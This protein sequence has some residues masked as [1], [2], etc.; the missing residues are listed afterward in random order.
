M[1]KGYKSVAIEIH[2]LYLLHANRDVFMHIGIEKSQ[3]NIIMLRV[4]IWFLAK[5]I[6]LFQSYWLKKRSEKLWYQIK[7]PSWFN[8]NKKK[9]PTKIIARFPNGHKWN[10]CYFPSLFFFLSKYYTCRRASFWA[11]MTWKTGVLLNS[12]RCNYT[13]FTYIWFHF[14]CIKTELHNCSIRYNF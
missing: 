12:L 13:F 11:W 8:N 7:T 4:D 14:T 5:N 3:F 10:Y 2:I 9:N 1:I 6:P